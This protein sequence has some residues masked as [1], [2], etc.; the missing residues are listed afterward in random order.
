MQ[1]TQ[2]QEFSSSSLQAALGALMTTGLALL[3]FNLFHEL[4]HFLS[5]TH[6]QSAAR[7]WDCAQASSTRPLLISLFADVI[8]S[9]LPH[10][11]KLAV[12]SA[13]FILVQAEHDSPLWKQR[14][15]FFVG[16]F[17]GGSWIAVG[18]AQHFARSTTTRP[19][20]KRH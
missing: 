14:L 8:P 3:L 7:L 2:T 16:Y 11:P 5:I 1:I 10:R 15:P 6:D 13:L 19:A 4:P 9:F 17:A 20:S 18:G 12:F